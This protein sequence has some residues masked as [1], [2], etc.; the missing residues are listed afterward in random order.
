[1]SIDLAAL[2][3]HKLADA[4]GLDVDDV[5]QT[6]TDDPVCAD[7]V[8]T[9]N[10]AYYSFKPRPDRPELFDQ[11]ASF[12]EA[13]DIVSFM[14]AGNGSGKTEGAAHKCARFLLGKQPPPRKDTPFWIL[15]KT[16]EMAAD[17]CWKEK[18]LGNGHIPRTEIEWERISWEDK[19]QWR[20]SD[21]P[22]KPWPRDK[23]G[24]SDRNWT[25]QFKS[26]EQGREAL[27]S[28]SI[29]GFWFSEQFPVDLLTET[30]VRCRDYLHPG[31]Q[32]CEF[33]PLE[34]DL[35]IW[36]EK[37]M[38]EMPAGWKIYRGNTECNR[39]NLATGAIEAFLATVPD[40]LIE[41]RLRGALA[42]F[43][44]A[45]Y[46]G[47]SLALHV[48]EDRILSRIPA[49]CWHAMS[50]DWGSSIEHPHVTLWG[51]IDGAGDWWIYDEYWSNDQNKTSYEHAQTI[52]ERCAAWGWPTT[53]GQVHNTQRILKLNNALD[54]HFGINFAD[55]SRPGE[56][57][58]F[59][60]Y[61]VPTVP[62]S[63]R[64]YDGINLVRSLLKPHP[65]TG[66]PR[67]KI[68]KRCKHLIDE[69]RKYRWRRA[70][71]PTEGDYLNPAVA[72]PVPLKREDDSCFPASTRVAT[73]FGN[74]KIS[75]I[76][77]GDLVLTHRGISE[78]IGCGQTGV[79]PL[80]KISLSDGSTL[81]CTARHRLATSN[82]QWIEASQSMGLQLDCLDRSF[83]TSRGGDQLSASP[84]VGMCGIGIQPMRHIPIETISNAAHERVAARRQ[85]HLSQSSCT[86]KSGSITTDQFRLVRMFITRIT[87]PAITNRGTSNCST[88][89]ITEEFTHPDN[90]H[91]TLPPNGTDRTQGV[92]GTR[93]MERKHGRAASPLFTFASD[94]GRN[95]KP[96][97]RR[98][99]DFALSTAGTQ[100]GLQAALITNRGRV[101]SA[102]YPSQSTVTARRNAARENVQPLSV[103]KI[104]LL[105]DAVPVFCLATSDG[106]F[107]AD[108]VLV[109]NCDA[110][111]YLVA[112]FDRGRSGTDPTPS[113][114]DTKSRGSVQ[115]DR[116]R[117]A[118]RPVSQG[119]EGVFRNTTR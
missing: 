87:T 97:S 81:R 109:S 60:C 79:E 74:V 36:L 105:P 53:Y 80:V 52:V 2:D 91:S 28:A 4:Y 16:K 98:T 92:S 8:N 24:H 77:K 111:R 40:E 61:G 65:I 14:V 44:G 1:M 88:S 39:D 21:V 35:C 11:Q 20:P 78:V 115:L 107:F 43:E 9:A 64:V 25:L 51:C 5:L 70:R 33:T 116:G 95:T 57:N 58:E 67:L 85:L 42:S 30:L 59:S 48:V 71:K 108:S 19:K 23:G 18:L 86:N 63:N 110:L 7:Y 54:P 106:T 10:S 69:L 72:A 102:E 45:I 73:L 6:L 31:G 15:N 62:A 119:L 113:R 37:L 56:I 29:G 118:A 32:F 49:G 26:Y 103:L 47:F 66:R 112:S 27:Q 22:L 117:Q 3:L 101:S 104:E 17:V 89:P 13:E 12:C 46:P 100:H 114:R 96:G 41:T 84:T 50:T 93:I 68:A 82:G 75:Q 76:R 94:A 55:P 83:L 99:I 90:R 38:E 34:P